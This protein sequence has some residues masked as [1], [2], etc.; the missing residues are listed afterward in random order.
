MIHRLVDM[1]RDH[2]RDGLSEASALLEPF[3]LFK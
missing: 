3:P 2:I 1:R